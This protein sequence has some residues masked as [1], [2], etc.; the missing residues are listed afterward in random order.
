MGS[1]IK[2]IFIGESIV[3]GAFRSCL[4]PRRNFLKFNHTGHKFFSKIQCILRELELLFELLYYAAASSPYTVSPVTRLWKCFKL[5]QPAKSAKQSWR[6][7]NSTSAVQQPWTPQSA[8]AQ[9]ISSSPT[10]QKNVRKKKR[11][12]AKF[13]YQKK[14]S[15]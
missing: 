12:K 14:Y 2:P 13:S 9:Y 4:T 10:P 6:G 8:H 3:L 1:S 11:K 7:H 15:Y 5:Y